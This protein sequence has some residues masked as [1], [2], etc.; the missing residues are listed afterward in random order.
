MR[1]WSMSVLGEAVYC[2]GV[3]SSLGQGKATTDT[4]L[5][6][7]LIEL[8]KDG[9]AGVSESQ[10]LLI[11]SSKGAKGFTDKFLVSQVLDPFKAKIQRDFSCPDGVPQ[12]GG[13]LAISAQQ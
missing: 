5:A 10:S 7:L 12:G 3:A 6:E 8:L 13:F 11:D 9:R 2:C 1:V 4:E